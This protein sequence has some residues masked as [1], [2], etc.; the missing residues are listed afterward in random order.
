MAKRMAMLVGLALMA[1]PAGASAQE[2]GASF[3]VRPH[4]AQP[5][6]V[7]SG[8]TGS[9]RIPG[10]WAYGVSRGTGGGARALRLSSGV[11]PSDSI[12][13]R[14][15]PAPVDGQPG[16]AVTLLFVPL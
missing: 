7:V 5:E 13:V 10:G 2:I 11:M 15:P 4:P 9:A 3:E 12:E 14:L 1:V 16:Q 8:S 6:L